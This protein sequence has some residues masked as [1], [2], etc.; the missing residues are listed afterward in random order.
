MTNHSSCL[1]FL[2]VRGSVHQV[3][4]HHFLKLPKDVVS[5]LLRFST[6]YLISKRIKTCRSWNLNALFLAL[7]GAFP[8]WT[9]FQFDLHEY[10]VQFYWRMTFSWPSREKSNAYGNERLLQ[11]PSYMWSFAMGLFC[12]SFFRLF[13]FYGFLRTFRY[14]RSFS[15]AHF[16]PF[17]HPTE[18]D[19]FSRSFGRRRWWFITY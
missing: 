16:L 10:R 15:T 7:V 3:S 17:H 8:V 5:F 14:V 4:V 2:K 1:W 9:Y 11:S 18:V 12:K 13:L 19:D 6:N